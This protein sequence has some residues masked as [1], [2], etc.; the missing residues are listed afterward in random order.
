MFNLML[1]HRQTN[2]LTQPT[3][4]VRYSSWEHSRK[5]INLGLNYRLPETQ[6]VQIINLTGKPICLNPKTYL[7]DWNSYWVGCGQKGLKEESLNWQLKRVKYVVQLVQPLATTEIYLLSSNNTKEGERSSHLHLF[8]SL[9]NHSQ[10]VLIAY[11]IQID[12]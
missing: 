10:V 2:E 12:E 6:E 8:S 1:N 9:L 11:W 5:V 4:V 7:E 3:E